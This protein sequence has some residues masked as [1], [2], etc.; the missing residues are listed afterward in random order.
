MY[1]QLLGCTCD[2]H[3]LCESKETNCFYYRKVRRRLSLT[4]K[5]TCRTLSMLRLGLPLA[6]PGNQ[7]LITL[8]KVMI[9]I[10]YG[11]FIVL[12]ANFR[13]HSILQFKCVPFD[14]D[15]ESAYLV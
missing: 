11:V 1:F 9:V 5:I 12:Q 6:A 2:T 3:L 15:S 14:S 4:V 10:S 13:F 7:F 8:E